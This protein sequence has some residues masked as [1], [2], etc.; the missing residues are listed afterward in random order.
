MPTTR[1]DPAAQAQI[2]AQ[3]QA[4]LARAAR[5]QAAHLVKERARAYAADPRRL[6]ALRPGLSA[7]TP[8]AL[9]S[10]G[11]ARLAAAGRRP[12]GPPLGFD[13]P[14]VGARAVILLA[15]AR[16]RRAGG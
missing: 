10:F 14:L 2:Q 6:E 9:L 1:D 7:A 3:V 4:L 12:A 16:R 8:A 15:R 11:R 5:R 13:P